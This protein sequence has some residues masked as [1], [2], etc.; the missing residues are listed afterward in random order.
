MNYPGLNRG[1]FDVMGG[2]ICFVELLARFS[3]Q[4]RKCDSTKDAD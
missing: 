1:D 2:C 4:T 3:R